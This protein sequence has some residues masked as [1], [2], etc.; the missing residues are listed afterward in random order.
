MSRRSA[1]SASRTRVISHPSCFSRRHFRS[2]DAALD[3]A[4]AL[5]GSR[6]TAQCGRCDGFHLELDT[7]SEPGRASAAGARARVGGGS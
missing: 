7:A 1:L 6:P 3:A 4:A 2:L 5:G